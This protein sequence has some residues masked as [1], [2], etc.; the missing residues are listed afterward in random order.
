MNYLIKL[1]PLQTGKLPYKDSFGIQYLA[2]VL[3]NREDKF[4]ES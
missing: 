3:K 4:L 2:Y 1:F